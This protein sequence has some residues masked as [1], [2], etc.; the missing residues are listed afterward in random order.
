MAQT[1]FQKIHVVPTEK[2]KMLEQLSETERKKYLSP[3]EKALEER[4]PLLNAKFQDLNP[5]QLEHVFS[6]YKLLLRN[7]STMEQLG[8]VDTMRA[9]KGS[10]YK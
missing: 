7:V 5:L 8:L 4:F 3:E 6:E 10:V 1:K 9:V 2:E